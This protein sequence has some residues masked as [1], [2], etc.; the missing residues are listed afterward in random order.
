MVHEACICFSV[1]FVELE[2]KREN[3]V[4]RTR[5]NKEEAIEPKYKPKPETTDLF[6]GPFSEDP[7]AIYSTKK[8]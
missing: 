2:R 6:R 8:K 4:R 7:S 3:I 1:T 5:N